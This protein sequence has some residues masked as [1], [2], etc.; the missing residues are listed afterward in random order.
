VVEVAAIHE[1]GLLGD[2]LDGQ[3]ERE[4]Q[5]GGMGQSCAQAE[6]TEADPHSVPEERAEVGSADPAR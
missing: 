6:F 1:P 4:E 5:V 3:V 2:S